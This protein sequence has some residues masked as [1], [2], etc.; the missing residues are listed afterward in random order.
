MLSD[1]IVKTDV[2]LKVVSFSHV[3]KLIRYH[4]AVPAPISA[5]VILLSPALPA[6]P[7][8]VSK[9]YEYISCNMNVFFVN[10]LLER[11]IQKSDQAT[12]SFSCE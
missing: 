1:I 7:L 11:N 6:V 8:F 2:I 12:F 10:S 3:S 9:L 5:T 4:P